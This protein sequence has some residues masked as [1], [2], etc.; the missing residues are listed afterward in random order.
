M[1]TSLPPS[2]EPIVRRGQMICQ[3]NTLIP[4]GRAFRFL[5]KCGEIES[6]A[7]MNADTDDYLPAFVIQYENQYFAYLNRCAH[8]AMELDWN[9][10]EMFDEEQKYLICAT[11]YA[12]YDPQSGKCLSGPCPKGAKLNALPIVLKDDGIYFAPL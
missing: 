8:V 3:Q 9:P 5:V 12:I 1:N 7:G 2:S 4:G 11:H 10:G 6:F